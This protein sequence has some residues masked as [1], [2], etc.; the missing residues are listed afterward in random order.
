MRVG[1]PE[2]DSLNE[3]P[4]CLPGRGYDWE[5][6]KSAGGMWSRARSLDNLSELAENLA[7]GREAQRYDRVSVGNEETENAD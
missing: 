7:D 3:L 6:A 2:T 1:P 4:L 5:C